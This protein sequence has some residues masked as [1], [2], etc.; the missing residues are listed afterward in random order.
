MSRSEAQA[1]EQARSGADGRERRAYIG[2]FTS[3]GGPGITTA[4]V[5]PRDGALTVLS[6]TAAVADPSYLVLSAGR[7][8]ALRGQRA[9]AEGA[10]AAFSLRDPAAPARLGPAVPVRGGA[11]THLAGPRPPAHRQ[12]R[13]RQRHPS[14][15][16][17]TDGTLGGVRHVLQHTGAGPHP[18]RQ[19]A[20]T[21]TRCCPTRAAGGWSAST[22]GRTR[23]GCAPWTRTG[24]C[25]WT[26]STR[27]APAS[28]RATW[29]STRAADHAY[30]VNE[31][32]SS[33]PSGLG[34]RRRAPCG[35][36][37][38]AGCCPRRGGR[39]ANYPSELVVSPDGR[40]A[41]AA[42]RGH[43]SIAVF[44]LDAERRA[45]RNWSAPCG[46]GGHWPRDLALDP[47]GGPPLRR[48][49]ALRGRHLVR[50]GP[51]HRHPEARG[52]AGAAR[53]RPACCSAERRRQDD[54]AP[55]PG[56]GPAR[57]R[58][59]ARTAASGPRARGVRAVRACQCIGALCA[60]G[61]D[62]ERGR[63]LRQHQL[64][65]RRVGPSASAPRRSRPPRR[66]S[67]QLRRAISGPIRHGARASVP[68]PEERNCS[69]VSAIAPSS[70]SPRPA[71]APRAVRRAAGR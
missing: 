47:V 61:R 18:E 21:P 40:F 49:R 60:L 25:G 15:R 53:G 28:G 46:C 9:P 35:R 2:S 50:R 24:G 55:V 66:R 13:L 45:A 4:G 16:G 10:A 69:A 48:Q 52:V 1:G 54:A 39:G 59:P 20:R 26:G 70:S 27:C 43:D 57:R 62:A 19:R 44:D 7:G 56:P 42:N 58:R 30:V 65:D 29:P 34:R 37:R 3:A 67:Q 41:W 8:G 5:D 64:A 32:D 36:S 23:C 71:P 12:L 11:P 6:R 68:E 63:V 33:S 51:R 38:R 31:L 22:S 14:G 17:R